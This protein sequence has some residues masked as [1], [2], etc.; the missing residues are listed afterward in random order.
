VSDWSIGVNHACYV[1]SGYATCWG[2][3][4]YGQLGDGTTVSSDVPRIVG[5]YT[6]YTSIDTTSYS[7]CGVHAD[8]QLSCW[9]LNAS[10]ELGTGAAD[11]SAHSSPARV[12]GIS[13]AAEVVLGATHACARRTDGTV[14]CWGANGSGQLGRGTVSAGVFAPMNV[15]LSAAATRIFAGN[16]TTCALLAD[17]TLS[18]W[19]SND[20]GSLGDGTRTSRGTPLVVPGLS[21]VV[22]A[23]VGANHVCVA[24]T[25]RNVWCWG[26]GSSGQLNP[27]TFSDQ[28]WAT[29][30]PSVTGAVEVNA[31][32][33]HSCARLLDS[34]ILCWGNNS[35]G[36]LGDGTYTRRYVPTAPVF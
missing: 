26:Q 13:S 30:G 6:D 11:Y 16:N 24:R 35:Y 4:S 36:E 10:G 22:S 29:I 18:C 12:A 9:G 21:G 27:A 15:A 20:Y 25:D 1:G 28:L 23:S 31:G 34:S 3:N 17:A 2:Q 19:G 7:T 32:D 8:G 33:Y 14:S 5:L